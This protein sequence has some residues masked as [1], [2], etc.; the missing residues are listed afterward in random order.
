MKF[1]K[2]SYSSLLL[3]AIAGSALL[4]DQTTAYA[5]SD[6]GVAAAVNRQ[7]RGTLPSGQVRTMVLGERIIFKQR[8]NTSGSGLVQILFTDGSALTVGAN[9]SLVIDEYV[10][11][12]NKGT[13]KLAVSFGKGVMRFVGGKLSKK[14]GGVTVRTT[15]G[16]AGIRGGMANIAVNRGKGVFSFLFGDELSFTG[17][18]GQRRRLYQPGYTLLAE[19][20]TGDNYK[21]LVTRRTLRGDTAFFQARLSGRRNQKGGA[22]RKPTNDMVANGPFPP[23]NSLIP[24]PRIK[25]R[26]IPKTIVATPLPDLERDRL[27]LSN[28]FNLNDLTD[29]HN[30]YDPGTFDPGVGTG[31]GGYTGGEYPFTE[32]QPNGQILDTASGC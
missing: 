14:K 20:G 26:T 4:S 10:Y 32:C 28:G 25:P 18:N 27:D 17:L 22:R 8:I 21:R 1:L 7:A 13:G 31:D 19:P 29:S 15:V 3:A 23:H 11:N 16:T 2:M 9:A 30:T 6:V 5:A 12:P 24:L